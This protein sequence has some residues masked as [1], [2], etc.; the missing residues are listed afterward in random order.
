MNSTYTIIS[1]VTNR[2]ASLL[3]MFLLSTTALAQS[4][5]GSISGTIQSEKGEALSTVNVALEGLSLAAITDEEGKFEITN[6]PAG[7]YTLVAAGIGYSANKQNVLI[8]ADKNIRLSL[9]LNTTAQALTEV[10]ITGN[11]N[12]F[13]KRET[14]Y[15]A[16]MPLENLENPQIYNT[17]SKE[18]L[19]EQV[20]TNFNDAIKNVPGL[21]K[22]WESTG[23][24]GDGAGY[25]SL[26]GFAVQPTMINGI[27]GLTNG[28]LDPANIERIEV[29]KGPSGT[30]FGSSVVSF[31]GLINIA[32][33]KPFDTYGGEISYTGGS[34]GLNRITADINSPI[35]KDKTLLLR[36][37][38]AYHYENSFQDVGFRK[39]SFI[40]PS[41]TYKASERLSFM[42]NTEYFN[43]ETTSP[44]MLFMNRTRQLK[45]RNPG[46]LNIDY[47]RSFTSNDITIRNPTFNLYGQA[48]YKLSD[49]W[50]SQ[51]IVSS[52]NRK[53]DGYYQYVMYILPGDSLLNR[54][55]S[56]QFSTG[57][58]TDIQQNFIGDFKIGN[59]R[60]RVVAGL[61]LFHIKNDN[62]N[63]AYI[64]FDTLNSHTNDPN[65]VK[66]NRAALDAKFA[67]N[68]SP[69]KN[70]TSN[71]TYSAYA[72]NV[73][74]IT[75][76]LMTMLSL[77][78]DHFD[79]KGTYT[80]ST[81]ATTGDYSQT[82]LSPKL[83]VVYQVV[84]DKVSLFAN[85][86]NGFRNVAPVTQPDGTVSNFKPQQA[87]QTEGGIKMELFN[88]KLSG[89]LSYYDIEVSNV[90]RPDLLKAGFSVQDGNIY[91]RGF[92]ADIIANPLYGLNIIAGYSYND[93]R[94]K[95]TN[96][97]IIDRRPTNAGPQHLV[98]TWISYT[99]GNGS[100]KGLGLGVG[101]NY[102][103]ENKITNSSITGE[104]TLPAYTVLNGTVFY[105]AK[106]F[107][108]GLKA[109][110]I[111][112]EN[113]W[114]GW[115]TAN[116][117]M[118]RRISA[119]I[120]FRL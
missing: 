88:G 71:Y 57:L 15:V 45:A 41:I 115:S 16:R 69:A 94:N 1:T 68:N 29:I 4:G 32:T 119:N 39:S 86:M 9:Q 93:S 105:N 3:F 60:N 102:A 17:V 116:P 63:S 73:L 56:D 95:V 77:R 12:K 13:A 61:D 100:L 106:T 36:V 6:V 70:S 18:L 79:N 75:D 11:G 19:Q 51:T 20:I 104:F 49:K 120:T 97:S 52:S 78:V 80:F 10:V 7:N 101:G 53:S 21:D 81:N 92:E 33:K 27:A 37:N 108:V 89:S 82:S 64:L 117:Q 25:F 59:L 55:V 22:L 83:G 5:K 107:R 8:Q 30:L 23:R 96:A 111:T 38:G 76:R 48:N 54:Y 103:S 47:N 87:N 28:G 114:K 43:S 34:Y 42:L 109:D 67:Q 24:A 98:N 66:L 113:Y 35:N 44:L 50:L 110:N 72:S 40:A 85:Y 31:G 62:S 91:S 84:K 99:L 118:T 26:R 74:N 112:D 65:Y 90:V 46:E 2:L 14:D 58:S